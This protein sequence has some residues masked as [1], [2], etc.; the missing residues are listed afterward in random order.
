VP[1]QARLLRFT[2]QIMASAML[3]AACRAPATPQL[4]LTPADLGKRSST[5]GPG[6]PIDKTLM[7][8]LR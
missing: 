3:S 2:R 4:R 7:H 1:F 8:A 6:L 5:G